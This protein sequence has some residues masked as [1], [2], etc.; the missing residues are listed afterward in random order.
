M[1]TLSERLLGE[2]RGDSGPN[3]C[4]SPYSSESEST[5]SKGKNTSLKT[6]DCF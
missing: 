6:N 5:V 3:P 4:N 2:G 1:E